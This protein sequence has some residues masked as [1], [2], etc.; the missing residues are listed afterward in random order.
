MKFYLF[1]T[2]F[3]LVPCFC[4]SDDVYDLGDGT[5]IMSANY[6][7]TGILVPWSIAFALCILSCIL[8]CCTPRKY[9]PATAFVQQPSPQVIFSSGIGMQTQGYPYTPNSPYQFTGGPLN[10]YGNYQNNVVPGQPIV[11]NNQ[12]IMN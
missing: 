12:G 8:C 7:F 9:Q 1:C 2:L 3:C 11:M 5:A 4:S 10:S 6:L